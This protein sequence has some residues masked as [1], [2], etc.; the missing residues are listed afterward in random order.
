MMPRFDL[1][2]QRGL[3]CLFGLVALT[4][5]A[6]AF[7]ITGNKLPDVMTGIFG[8]MAAGPVV[9]STAEKYREAKRAE[10]T[11]RSTQPEA[12]EEGK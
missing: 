5:E 1:D 4:A 3:I 9:S 2:A 11:D 8:T 6:I 12:S 10:R 7:Y